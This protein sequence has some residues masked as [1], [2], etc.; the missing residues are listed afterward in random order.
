MLHLLVVDLKHILQSHSG[1]SPGG[2]DWVGLGE[3]I[4]LS[5]CLLTLSTIVSMR[6]SENK[7]MMP[8][9]RSPSEHLC[10][11]VAFCFYL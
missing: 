1:S 3:L 9:C 2:D 10:N 4:V 7:L 6:V 5:V 8:E 11:S